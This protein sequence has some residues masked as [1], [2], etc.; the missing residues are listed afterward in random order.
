M[1]LTG[2]TA[3]LF[4]ME[5]SNKKENPPVEVTDKVSGFDL[6]GDGE[7][8]LIRKSDGI[9]VTDAN[10]KKAELKDAKVN[11]KD[12]VFQIDPVEDWK[13]MMFGLPGGWS[14]II[15]TIK[16]CTAWTGKL[17]WTVIYHWL[18]E[19]QTVT[20]LTT[21]WQAWFQNCRALHTFVY[22]GDKRVAADDIT[23]ASLGARLEKNA[24]KGGYLIEHIYGGDPDFPEK[25][26]PLSQPQL[27]ISGWG[28]HH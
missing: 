14:V 21:C 24:D 13:Q 25:R 8:L 12:W 2:R 9:Y 27:Q 26:S 28:C 20:N 19:L 23:P 4:T 11:L 3:K 16:T 18:S 6:S 15:F 22:G 5:I 7:K 17:C 10:G 1:L